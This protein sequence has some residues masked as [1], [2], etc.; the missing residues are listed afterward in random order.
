MHDAEGFPNKAYVPIPPG[1]RA[2]GKPGQRAYDSVAKLIYECVEN[3]YWVR[4]PYLEFAGTQRELIYVSALDT[5]GLF[6][7]MGTQLGTA[8]WAN[9]EAASSVT[10]GRLLI[11]AN[12]TLTFNAVT[13]WL[14]GVNYAANVTDRTLGTQFFHTDNS[15]SPPFILFDLGNIVMI[16]KTMWFAQRGDSTTNQPT[17]L[18]VDGSNDL[19]TFTQL[20]P[21]TTVAT[22]LGAQTVLTIVGITTAYRYLKVISNATYMNGQEVEFYGTVGY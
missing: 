8:A 6:Y 21:L 13:G 20:L 11:A 4:Y 1:S 5:N 14:G 17:Q 16:P 18:R 22:G 19:I 12:Q 15:V 7:F 3:N 2:P 10:P 9:P